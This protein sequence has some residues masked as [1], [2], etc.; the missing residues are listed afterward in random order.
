MG[1]GSCVRTTD[2]DELVYD[3]AVITHCGISRGRREI[4]RRKRGNRTEETEKTEKRERKEDR[5]SDV[6]HIF[7]SF[8]LGTSYRLYLSEIGYGLFFKLC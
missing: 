2:H 8:R 6:S 4:A 7:S 3:A 5:V 1:Y